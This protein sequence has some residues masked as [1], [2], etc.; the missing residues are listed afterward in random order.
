M[1]SKSSGS[2]VCAA[3]DRKSKLDEQEKTQSSASDCLKQIECDV[4]EEWKNKIKCP[5]CEKVERWKSEKN[6]G[7]Q[8]Y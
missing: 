4:I 6:G 1:R 8:Q 2:Q 5:K 3:S 7:K